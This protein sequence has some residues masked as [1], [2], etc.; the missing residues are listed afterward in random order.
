M[1]DQFTWIPIYKELATKLLDYEE[2]QDELLAV[3]KEMDNKG[4]P[5]ISLKDQNREG[6]KIDLDGIDPFTFLATVNRNLK[7]E[8]REKIIEF[9]KQKFELSSDIPGDFKGIPVVD[10]RQSWF[11]AYSQD[12]KPTDITSLWKVFKEVINNVLTEEA[13]KNA[14]EVKQV[15]LAKLTQ[16][17]FWVAPENYLPLDSKTK[18]YLKS[19]L[20][21]DVEKS[22][23]LDAYVKVMENAKKLEKSFYEIS[24]EAHLESEAGKKT[25]GQK[26]KK[27]KDKNFDKVKYWVIAHG[28]KAKFW[29][30]CLKKGIIR[31]GWNEMNEDLS[32]YWNEDDLKKRH[33]GGDFKGINDF[34]NNM[35]IGDYLFV[36][37]GIN[38]LIGYGK[39]VSDY[40][41]DNSLETYRHLRRVQ[42][43]KKGEVSLP[44]K[45][46]LFP[47]HTLKLIDDKAMVD[48]LLKLVEKLDDV[49]NN[50]KK[51][52]N[53]IYYGPPGTGKTYE[54]VFKA[55]ELI[56]GQRPN[57]YEEA[58][59]KYNRFK[60]NGQVEFITFHQSYS[61]EDFIEGIRPVKKE[62]NIQYEVQDGVFKI[63]CEKAEE[64]KDKN[65]VLI[66][67]E[68]NRGNISKIFGELITLIEDDKRIGAKHGIK[69]ILPYSK[70]KFGVPNNLYIVGTMNTADR[71]IALIDT[72][73]RRRFEFIEMMPKPELFSEDIDGINLQTM[74]ETINTRIEALYDRD[75]QIGHAYFLNIKNY[76]GLCDVFAKKIIPLLQEYFY[77][78]WKKIT[79]VLSDHHKDEKSQIIQNTTI[80]QKE[81]FGEVEDYD[82][83]VTIYTVNEKLYSGDIQKEAFTKIYNPNK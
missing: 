81:L 10:N 20:N 31:V 76:A 38:K 52:K 8:N 75:H 15:G 59:K 34:V 57:N 61:Y 49:T 9:L 40:Q 41:F 36:R 53:L 32:S 79:L 77:N 68:I 73:L 16:G 58:H 55:L 18:K 23:S 82:D 13:F 47:Q 70:E 22:I 12:R 39:V 65:F 26:S 25:S 21:V 24:L 80:S 66:I 5:V 4:L 44:K 37:K 83:D 50:L 3:L 1:N 6:K 69:A 45:T 33:Q 54:T 43:L 17:L 30:D 72:A 11:F 78:D 42:W 67:D 51:C 62:N 28:K 56:N 19:H 2:R 14:L 7:D 48:D 64:N 27:S 60:E 63:I 74:L 35:K 46:K 71:S 29:D